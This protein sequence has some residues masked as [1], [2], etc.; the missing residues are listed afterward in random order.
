MESGDWQLSKITTHKHHNNHPDIA[1]TETCI[2]TKGTFFEGSETLV[3]QLVHDNRKEL[4][5]QQSISL[6]CKR[7]MTI[8]TRLPEKILESLNGHCL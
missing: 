8:C 5:H 1:E 6:S 2:K 4:D 3:T 7:I